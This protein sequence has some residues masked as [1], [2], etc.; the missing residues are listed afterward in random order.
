ME[1][2]G[3]TKPKWSVAGRGEPVL[4]VR[5]RLGKEQR[6]FP[7]GT[8]KQPSLTPL[9]LGQRHGAEDLEEPPSEV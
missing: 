1:Q 9:C 3:T 7:V 8:K 4:L 6:S 2:R 5:G